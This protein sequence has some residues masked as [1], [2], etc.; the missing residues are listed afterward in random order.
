[1]ISGQ[2]TSRE[3][4]A[5][6]IMGALL[7]AATVA[8]LPTRWYYLAPAPALALMVVFMMWRRPMWGFALM[9]FF[10]PF[11]Q[12]RS[13]SEQ[14]RWFTISKL[15]GVLLVLLI[16]S[17]WLIL[18]KTPALRSRMWPC[19]GLFMASAVV[20]SFYTDNLPTALNEL[21]QMA[22]A[23]VFFALTL[24]LVQYKSLFSEVP[25]AVVLGISGSA[26]LSLYGYATANPLFAMQ[27]G[28]EGMTRA[29]GGSNDPNLF[30]VSLLFSLPIL[31]HYF[32][33][34]RLTRWRVASALL[35]VINIMAL[36][37]TFSRGGALNFLLLSVLLCM[38]H[39]KRLSPRKAGLLL[40]AVLATGLMVLAFIPSSYWERQRS[41]V[42][43]SD[44]SI[45]RRI[46]YIKV[47]WNQFLESPLIGHGPGVFKEL[48]AETVYSGDIEK[49]LSR[50][51]LRPAHN[52]YLEMLVGMGLLGLG[53]Y[54]CVILAA[55][56]NFQ[57]AQRG[58]QEA[59]RE[60]EASMVGAYKIA[61]MVVL[62]Y[63]L[64]LSAQTHKFFWVSLAFSQILLAGSLVAQKD[65]A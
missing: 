8:L 2:N 57:K 13:L 7:I 32:F 11:D 37:I 52:T 53:F 5:V 63:F 64:I 36:V 12:Y 48:W 30:S 40:T 46:D 27:V 45:S 43:T 41:V 51:Y 54:L 22:T 39:Y 44:D 10:V 33:E 62:F 3:N 35:T 25:L 59:G 50:G 26:L 15:V 24:C 42:Q 38:E 18:H 61:F 58:L 31:T 28:G 21:R 65:A 29:V 6:Y 47:G 4:P 16:L 34:A 60:R 14:F 9:I 49:G 20:A 19:L 55:L 23:V 1:M 17:R 56:H